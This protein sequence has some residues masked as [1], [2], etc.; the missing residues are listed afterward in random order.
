MFKFYINAGRP[1]QKRRFDQG[2]EGDVDLQQNQMLY[3]HCGQQIS[4]VFVRERR[5]QCLGPATCTQRST[6]VTS[7]ELRSRRPSVVVGAAGCLLFTLLIMIILLLQM[8]HLH[9]ITHTHVHTHNFSRK[10]I[11]PF[12]QTAH[13]LSLSR[14]SALSLTCC[15]LRALSPS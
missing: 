1:G 7:S 9:V 8:L 4:P 14:L 10:P 11:H 2:T 12:T 6:T 5:Q 3:G 15:L 13:T